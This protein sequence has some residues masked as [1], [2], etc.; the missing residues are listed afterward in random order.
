VWRVPPQDGI[1]RHQGQTSSLLADEAILVRHSED[2]VLSMPAEK[3]EVG[4]QFENF[5]FLP[6]GE[7]SDHRLALRGHRSTQAFRPKSIPR[8]IHS[9]QVFVAV[10]QT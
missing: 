2:N 5:K 1:L 3:S 7:E 6:R 8:G 10:A 4:P 9:R